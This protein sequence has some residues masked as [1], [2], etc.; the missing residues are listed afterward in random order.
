MI[1]RTLTLLACACASAMTG[2]AQ[3]IVTAPFAAIPLGRAGDVTG[4]GIDDLLV[5][6]GSNFEVLDA[7]T[8]API[9]WLQ[10][11]AVAFPGVT[12]RYTPVGDYDGDGK[13][14]LFHWVQ[15]N[16]SGVFT[17]VSGA[18]GSALFT[19][20]GP[21]NIGGGTDFDG[22]GRSDVLY[23]QG[24]YGIVRSART[25]AVLHQLVPPLL[26]TTN[27]PFYTGMTPAGDENGD[28]RG[29]VIANYDTY[30]FTNLLRLVVRA[31]GI[32]INLERATA[33]G[34]VT[35]DGKADF[36]SALV[37]VSGQEGIFAGGSSALVWP[38]PNVQ[39]SPL[40]DVDGDGVDDITAVFWLGTGF[41]YQPR[42]GATHVALPGAAATSAPVLLGDID[43]D[44]RSDSVMSGLR[45][46]WS[47]PALPVASRMLRRGKPGTT[48]DGRK[49]YLVTRGHCGLG[50]T[51]FFD[52]RGG[53]PNGLTLLFYGSS[54]DVDLAGIGAPN[55][56]CYTSLAGGLAFV[57]N[58]DGIAQYQATMPVTPSLL[59]ASLS[60]QSV[61]VDPAANAL[62]LVTS[63]A[64]D[65]TT[66]N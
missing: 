7:T 5:Q 53:L 4:D 26:P 37:S 50:H 24:G 61:V 25:G 11:N 15:G 58:A 52:M 56:R 48:N 57:A 64:V 62:G 47:D 32:E 1:P 9:P 19:I 6:I 31:P 54:I 13:D 29:D 65:I 30:I 33:V 20:N 35:G 43:G 3:S 23:A 12:L 36:W 42:S 8:N 21:C 59:G 16:F 45:Y 39:A 34:D 41:V 49:P 38:M 66:N 60:L 18:D 14:D 46:E 51:A 27:S 44:G 40:G 22:D 63:N 10:R 2:H 28:G 55:N 17:L